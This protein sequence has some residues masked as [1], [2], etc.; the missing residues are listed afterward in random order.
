MVQARKQI[1]IS[2]GIHI[3]MVIFISTSGSDRPTSF[4]Q[5]FASKEACETAKES[6]RAKTGNGKFALLTCE[7]KS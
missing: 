2:T 4:T 1:M 3:L 6:V 5:E 7:K